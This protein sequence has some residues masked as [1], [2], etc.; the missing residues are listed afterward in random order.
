M[1]FFTV[2]LCKTIVSLFPVTLCI[3][4]FTSLHLEMCV[5]FPRYFVYLH[6]LQF[7]KVQIFFVVIL[8]SV[9]LCTWEIKYPSCYLM[10]SLFT[11]TLC[12]CWTFN[13]QKS[14]LSLWS[15]LSNVTLCTCKIKNP[16]CKMMVLLFTVT[17]C[18]C[19]ICKFQKSKFSL[20]WSLSNVTL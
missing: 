7:S 8:S 14:K 1:F 4:K 12:T 15:S 9:T 6:D 20:W 18:T 17:L 19:W 13:F 3:C 16:S 5:A 2:T 10:V 11:V